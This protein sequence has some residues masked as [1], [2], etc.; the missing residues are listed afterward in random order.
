MMLFGLCNVPGCFE[1]LMESV[2]DG[3][4]WKMALVYLDDDIIFGSTFEKELELLEEVLL[5]LRKANLKLSPK[6]WSFF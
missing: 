4:Q 2:L 3:L 1:Q 5:K 6:K